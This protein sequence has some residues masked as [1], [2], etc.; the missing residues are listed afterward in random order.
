MGGLP[1][2]QGRAPVSVQVHDE[3]KQQNEKLKAKTSDIEQINLQIK[4]E[5]SAAPYRRA[6]PSPVSPAPTRFVRRSPTL[7]LRPPPIARAHPPM[8]TKLRESFAKKQKELEEMRQKAEE[9]RSA[10]KNELDQVWASP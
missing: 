2:W 1:G 5:A 3:N 6:T 8:Q 7:R 9:R 4:K 10:A